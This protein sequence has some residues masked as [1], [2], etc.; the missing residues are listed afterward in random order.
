MDTIKQY[1]IY[2]A[3]RGGITLNDTYTNDTYTNDTYPNNKIIQYLRLYIIITKQ[4][5]DTNLISPPSQDSYSPLLTP[6]PP[7]LVCHNES[8]ICTPDSP[9]YASSYDHVLGKMVK[10]SRYTPWRRLGGEEV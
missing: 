6:S 9:Q 2:K 1:Y 4:H 7:N 3:N 10:Q 5:I 8:I